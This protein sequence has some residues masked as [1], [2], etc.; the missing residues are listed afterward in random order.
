MR[1]SGRELRDLLVAWLVLGLAFALFFDGGG[2]EFVALLSDPV[3][4]GA[5]LAVSLVTAGV[6]FVAHELA[7][8]Y[9]AVRF[10]QIA[11]FRADYGMLFLGVM[12]ALIGFLF[13]APGAVHH[14]GRLTDRQRGLV[15][16]AGPAANVALA[17]PFGVV[18]LGT[19]VG[20]AGGAGGLLGLVGAR[21]LVVNL[22]LAAF[23]LVP[24]RSLDGA[25]VRGWSTAAWLGAF[26]PTLAAAVLALFA[27]DIGI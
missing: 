18:V 24:I 2:S 22:F 4:L 9:V 25:T 27:V 17:V 12:S 20:S 10:D 13:V 21:G 16:L 23:N 5:A 19:G 6:A 26:L 14:R 7:H 1:F 8:K 11:E 3:V 15:A